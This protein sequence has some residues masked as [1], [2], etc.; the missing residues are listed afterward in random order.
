MGGKAGECVD[1]CVKAAKFMYVMRM[2][3]QMSRN[4]D[5]SLNKLVNCKDKQLQHRE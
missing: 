2:F 5:L 4:Q 3:I 1:V